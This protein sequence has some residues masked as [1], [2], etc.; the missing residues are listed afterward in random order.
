M[1][2]TTPLVMARTV[3]V[4]ALVI[5]FGYLRGSS[6]RITALSEGKRS[7]ALC[8]HNMAPIPRY[9]VKDAWLRSF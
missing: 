6:G 2:E 3:F 7:K 4:T 9:R 8:L 1:A 5:S